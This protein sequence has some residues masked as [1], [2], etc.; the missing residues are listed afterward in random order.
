ME[1]VTSVSVE[2]DSEVSKVRMVSEVNSEVVSSVVSEVIPVL[3][4]LEIVVP[5]ENVS[6]VEVSS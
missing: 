1:D 5:S 2:L 6:P 3:K 4:L